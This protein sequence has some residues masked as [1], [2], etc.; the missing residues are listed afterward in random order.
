MLMEMEVFYVKPKL[1][2]KEAAEKV[3]KSI[4]GLFGKKGDF[5]G[6]HAAYYP[7]YEVDADIRS[8]EPKRKWGVVVSIEYE[9]VRRTVSIDGVKGYL[10]NYTF[11]PFPIARIVNLSKLEVEIARGMLEIDKSLKA[12]EITH[13]VGASVAEVEAALKNLEERGLLSSSKDKW[14][15]SDVAWTMIA[16]IPDELSSPSCVKGLELVRG[17]PPGPKVECK[18]SIEEV[19][20]GVED[21]LYGKVHK[22]WLT[23]CPFYISKIKQKDGSVK[24]TV[25]ELVKGDIVG[26]EAVKALFEAM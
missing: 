4:K 10:C 22:C 11:Q 14:K 13:Y 12:E 21:I 24:V 6:G 8:W 5:L 17:E 20:R 2:E 23:Y 7:F 19:V 25:V 18:I 9:H 15:A 1:S 26:D 3:E 16:L